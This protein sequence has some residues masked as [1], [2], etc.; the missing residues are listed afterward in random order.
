MP[1]AASKTFFRCNVSCCQRISSAVS[2]THCRLNRAW[3]AEEEVALVV[4]AAE[5]WERVHQWCCQVVV[6]Q[7]A[8]LLLLM[9]RV[10]VG[11][12][13]TLWAVSG[14]RWMKSPSRKLGSRWPQHSATRP[15]PQYPSWS[16][17]FSPSSS[18][19]LLLHPWLIF[20][21]LLHSHR[22]HCHHF[23]LFL[24]HL[25]QPSQLQTR[26][27]RR[28]HPRLR[29]RLRSRRSL[30]FLRIQPPRCLPARLPANHERHHHQRLVPRRTI[31]PLR[32]A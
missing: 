17:M 28:P 31:K 19:H 23:L 20:P 11:Q 27:I 12:A 10:C 5:V 7:W 1:C 32:L 14:R 29:L 24:H 4:V 9:K 16:S 21:S 18:C 13:Q 25:L 30:Q 15:L 26:R 6:P 22:R 3:Q 8:A 2:L